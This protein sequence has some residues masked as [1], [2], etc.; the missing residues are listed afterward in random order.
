MVSSRQQ[1]GPVTLPV[2]ILRKRLGDTLKLWVAFKE[3]PKEVI[4][5]KASAISTHLHWRG[6]LCGSAALHR[7]PTCMNMLD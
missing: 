6:R 3:A 5:K 1:L 2:P 7:L 4:E